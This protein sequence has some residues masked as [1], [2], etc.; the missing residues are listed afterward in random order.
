[1][2]AD[3]SEGSGRKW[4]RREWLSLAGIGG[5]AAVVGLMNAAFFRSLHLQMLYEPSSVFRAGK[6]Q[7]YP[8]DSVVK[9]PGRPVFICRDR[10]GLFAISAVCTHLGCIIGSSDEGFACPCHGSVYDPSG[11]VVGGPA[12]RNLPWWRLTLATDGQLVVNAG[13]LVKRGEKLKILT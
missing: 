10:E 4:S 12:P 5:S 7:H 6:P 9:V 1:M 2:P 3:Q 8:L 13:T 11:K